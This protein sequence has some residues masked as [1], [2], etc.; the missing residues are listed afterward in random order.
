MP[1]G[2][3]GVHVHFEI[4]A[5]RFTFVSLLWFLHLALILMTFA[6][7][8]HGTR[9]TCVTVCGLDREDCCNDACMKSVCMSM[10]DV[11]RECPPKVFAL[12]LMYERSHGSVPLMRRRVRLRSRGLK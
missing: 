2:H 1:E 6:R 3:R 5:Y 10:H 12:T 9:G 11:R 4:E 7:I 8:Q